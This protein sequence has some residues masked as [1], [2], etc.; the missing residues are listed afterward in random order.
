MII[1]ITSIIG[2]LAVAELSRQIAH[3]STLAQDV[4][5]LIGIDYDNHN[6]WSVIAKPMF[7]WKFTGRWFFLL[8]PVVLFMLIFS[9]TMLFMTNLFDCEYC[10]GYHLGWITL[11]FVFQY[12]IVMALLFAPLVLV[13]L[14][15]INRI[16][17]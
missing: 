12:S 17:R 4:K 8:L 2:L 7:W 11:F 10:L 6:R 9:N 15:V 1:T 16:R 14:H 3:E 13:W 5:R